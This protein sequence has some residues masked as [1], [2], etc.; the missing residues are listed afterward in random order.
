MEYEEII[1]SEEYPFDTLPQ[2]DD[3]WMQMASEVKSSGWISVEDFLNHISHKLLL[4]LLLIISS[5]ISC[6]ADDTKSNITQQS[7]KVNAV[8]D[9]LN[10]GDSITYKD[11]TYYLGWSANPFEGYYVQEYFP[12]GEVAD[13]YNQMFTVSVH[14]VEGLTPEIATAAKVN[15]LEQRKKTDACCNYKVYKNGEDRMLDFLVSAKDPNN[16]ELLSTV[17]FDLHLYK[18]V[19]IKG[20]PALQLLFYSKRAYGD[21]IMPFLYSL[22]DFRGEATINM[23]KSE[24]KCK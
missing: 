4:T 14:Y 2:N 23:V 16:S 20:K 11:E 18:Q 3:E 10:V 13:H 17:E 8:K 5:S 12:K 1:D 21:D 24:I 19:E 6:F 22:K 9:Y 15:E 7:K